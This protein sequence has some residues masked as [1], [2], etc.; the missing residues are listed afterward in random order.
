MKH[1]FKE[2]L[3]VDD[4]EIDN[5]VHKTVL[6]KMDL[7]ETITTVMNG[8]EAIEYL[9]EAEQNAEKTIP[10]LIFLDIN[11]PIMDGWEF[12]QVARQEDVIANS[13]VVMMLTTSQNPDDRARAEA[14]GKLQGFLTKPLTQSAVE[15]ILNEQFGGA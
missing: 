9:T 15:R 1:R 3:L 7:A 13:V 12:I 14:G 6:Q 2:I 4:S 8:Q 11:M 5:F 10:E